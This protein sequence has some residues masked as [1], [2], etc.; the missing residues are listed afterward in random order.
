MRS[1]TMQTRQTGFSLI[2]LMVALVLGLILTSGVISVYITSKN[3]YNVNTALGAVQEHGRFSLMFMDPQIRM[4]G[5]WGCRKTAPIPNYVA[6]DSI[7]DYTSA[8][9]GYEATGTGVGGSL[10]LNANPSYETTPPQNAALWSPALNAS[11]T[12]LYNAI[13]S[14]A[15][16][17]SDIF[18]IRY[19][20]SNPPAL[21]APTYGDGTDPGNLYVSTNDN[22]V[23][24]TSYFAT[25]GYAVVSA[26]SATVAPQAF[27]VTAI[28]TAAGTVSYAS[29]LAH[30]TSALA[31]GNLGVAVTY[32]YWV[33]KG[34]DNGPSL[35]QGVVNNDGSFSTR[36]LVSGVENM[37][38]LYGVDTDSDADHVPNRFETA[39]DVQNEAGGAAWSKV[40]CIRVALLTRSDDNSIDK[41]PSSAQTY[42]MMASDPQA[43]AN[44]DAM[45]LTVPIDRRLRRY[46]VQTFS[47]RN[48]LP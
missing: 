44:G 43:N 36:E 40:V 34:A 9:F 19:V 13:K 18:M 37:Q 26:C 30:Y 39:S 12:V 20:N 33:G 47:M 8:V 15:L 6:S 46:F 1:H 27:K 45:S 17:G 48:A 42:F 24:D 14:T 35:Y 22:G 3:T 7:Y 21:I 23:N 41:A 29:L 28:D 32:V 25:N 38:V 2:E 31:T 4:A 10:D 5:Y 11:G 16:R